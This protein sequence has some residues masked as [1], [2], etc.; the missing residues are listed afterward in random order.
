MRHTTGNAPPS[1]YTATQEYKCP[2]LQH[3][4]QRHGIHCHSPNCRRVSTLATHHPSRHWCVASHC[5]AAC[6][7]PTQAM[8]PSFHCGL[9]ME[10]PLGPPWDP[11]LST[12]FRGASCW[13]TPSPSTAH[14]FVCIS[15]SVHPCNS[16]HHRYSACITCLHRRAAWLQRP[17]VLCL[18]P[19]GPLLKGPTAGG[20]HQRLRLH[21]VLQ[22]RQGSWKALQG[23]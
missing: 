22:G 1:A 14:K 23:Q 8:A 2:F 10:G 20:H 4:G 21:T 11:L 19:A 18:Q 13:W 17:L 9:T 5:R 15:T 16:R 7:V 6:K 3:D 12:T